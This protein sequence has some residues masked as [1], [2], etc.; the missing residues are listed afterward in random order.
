MMLKGCSLMRPS[1]KDI[2]AGG[3]DYVA[4]EL[5]E[6]CAVGAE[7]LSGPEQGGCGG[8]GNGWRD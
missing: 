1:F 4:L 3:A 6:C 2:K 5:S 7:I 8:A